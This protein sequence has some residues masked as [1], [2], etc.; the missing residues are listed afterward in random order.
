MSKTKDKVIEAMNNGKVVDYGKQD[1]YDKIQSEYDCFITS[2]RM[3]I[4][5]CKNIAEMIEVF[6]GICTDGHY[7]IYKLD[8]ALSLCQ[9]AYDLGRN[10]V[11]QTIDAIAQ[12]HQE[13]KEDDTTT[14]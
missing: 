6:D 4:E 8:I 1:F 7:G 11:L 14:D 10:A 13:L 3:Q 9:R 2:A 12:I 5:H